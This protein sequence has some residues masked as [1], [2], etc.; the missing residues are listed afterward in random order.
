MLNQPA[1]QA[2]RDLLSL[3]L[4]VLC[5][6]C[7]MPRA[8]AKGKQVAE[9]NLSKETPVGLPTTP[10]ASDNGVTTTPD[11]LPV[12]R[13][14]G[15]AP[16]EKATT[17]C[18]LSADGFLE[19]DSDEEL[20][21]DIQQ[22]AAARLRFTA[23]LL[24]PFMLQQELGAVIN[25][26]WTLLRKVWISSLTEGA[27]D[28]A[29]VQTLPATYVVKQHFCRLQ[30]SFLREE[31]AIAVRTK[32]VEY[33][34]PKGKVTLFWQHTENPA[35]LKEKASNPDV[36][37]LYFK[38]VS[39]NVSPD[40]L[41][42]MLCRY[43]LKIRKSSAFAKGVCRSGQMNKK[44]MFVVT[45]L[46]INGLS[47]AAKRSAYNKWFKSAAN[48]LI[49]TDMRVEADH[50][51][52]TQ[53]NPS[54][55]AAV[56][57]A[58]GAGGVAILSFTPGVVFK[59]I[60]S[61]ESGRLVAVS[62][63]KGDMSWRIIAA[64]FPAQA[65]ARGVFF[66]DCLSTFVDSLPPVPHTILIG[67]LN[68][69]ADPRIDKSSKIGSS[70]ENQRLL[71]IFTP[72]DMQDTFRTLHPTKREYTFYAHSAKERSR[73][74]RALVSQSLLHRV[75]NA[76]H[77][78][79][80]HGI[81]DHWY[82]VSVDIRVS[83][84]ERRGPGLWKI[85]A[86]Q[87][88]MPGVKKRIQLIMGE[89]PQQPLPSFP[90]L[91]VKL[92][93]SIRVYA[94]EEKKRVKKTMA[95]L[96]ATV[97]QLKDEFM[98][99]DG[100]ADCYEQLAKYGSML[101]AYQD[102]ERERLQT[103]AGVQTEVLGELPSPVLSSRIA[104]KRAQTMI[105][106]VNFNGACF[107]GER[108]ILI[109]ASEYFTA[110]FA[111]REAEASTVWPVAPGKTLSAAEREGL[112]APWTVEEVKLA[113]QQL[114][115]GKAPGLDGL[116]KELLEE[117][118]DL[119]GSCFMA[120]VKDFERSAVLTEQFMTA[121]TILLHKKGDKSM[122]ENYRPITLLSATYKIVAKVLANR[123]KKV[124]PSVISDHQ[125]GFLPGRKL[126]DAVNV[127]A[128]VIDAA[129]AGR[130][131]WY[132]L[133][134]DFQKAYDSIS[135]R[136]LF[137]T[138]TR[139][140]FPE[141]YVKWA[142]GLHDHSV[143][144]LLINGRLGDRVEM[145]RGVR[146]GCPLAPYL[147]ICAAEPL[148]QE[149]RRRRL[150]VWKRGVG[151][152]AYLGYADD[153]SI[154]LHRKEQI[155]KACKLLDDFGEISGL[156]VNRGKTVVVPLGK[157]RG[158]PPPS[159]VPYTW[160][161]IDEPQRLLGIWITSGGNPEPSWEK[162]ADRA[163][164]VLVKWQ[165]Q[166]VKTSARV[167]V[168]NSYATPILLFQ[169][170]VY[171]PPKGTWKEF[172]ATSH[173]FTSSGKAS[174]DKHFVLWSGELAYMDSKEGG[175]GVI[176]PTMRVEC[177]ALKNLGDAVQQRDQ[178]KRWL[179]ERAAGMPFGWAT[180]LAHRS[181]LRIWNKGGE[182]W[183]RSVITFWQVL[184]QK[185]PAPANRWDYAAERICFSRYIFYRGKSPFGRQKGSICL[186]EL[187]VGDLLQTDWDGTKRVKD[188][189]A[190]TKETGSS[191]TAR[192]ALKAWKAVPGE[193]KEALLARLTGG[194]VLKLTRFA[195]TRSLAGKPLYWQLLAEDGDGVLCKPAEVGKR[196]ELLLS[197]RANQ[198]RVETRRLTPLLVENDLL[199]GEAG[200]ALT[201]L[202]LSVLCE[203]GKGATLKK[204]RA[205]LKGPVEQP[206]QQKKWEQEYGKPVDW[207]GVIR[208]RDTLV[209][210]GSAREIILRL[211]SKNLQVG[212]R[213]KFMKDRISCPHCAE[214]ETLAHCLLE[215]GCIQ[216]VIGAVKG[217]LQQMNPKR[218]VERLEDFLFGADG[219]MSGFPEKPLIAVAFHQIW[220]ERC[221]A[222]FRQGKF[223]PQRVLR[224]IGVNFMKHVRIYSAYKRQ[225]AK[226]DG[227]S[228]ARGWPHLAQ[229][230]AAMLSRIFEDGNSLTWREGFRSV[231]ANPRTAFQP[232]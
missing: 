181:I 118:W 206:K 162:A 164:E 61:H 69:I 152:V 63:E 200:L 160:A 120:F 178:M 133:L 79:V 119:L 18:Q 231:W 136:Y 196:G 74:D 190:L 205:V 59:D 124:L 128:D 41:K 151:D 201:R 56:S 4:P 156:K 21:I 92:Q 223:Q 23:I 97:S 175:L 212:E 141:E 122:L 159:D 44:D 134:V 177:M 51:F 26:V 55:F 232:P 45:A 31:D 106:E 186:L 227:R 96:E 30:L 66:R 83:A 16:A 117:N 116:P 33:Q 135:R 60:H 40:L 161:G 90:E 50:N 127:V 15:L 225:V 188:M 81:S 130:E 102:E 226:S 99:G 19:D 157:N 80:P 213:L 131:D 42:D 6:Q 12:A 72:L 76:Y 203:K 210:P 82:A 214:D 174:A 207:N 17:A 155:D 165:N 198:L 37:E 216:P 105:E 84:C 167:S 98:N 148:S 114:P 107:T 195:C 218:E 32:T 173:N 86:A 2:F 199:M 95:R 170:Q 208:K 217:A 150:G 24:V 123:I 215:C 171:P 149:I 187:T 220:L 192:W 113:I 153:T 140:G 154:V 91:L 182:K 180:L 65:T 189:W 101:K 158:L 89:D 230:E 183:R 172:R 144:Q 8:P 185:I 7:K 209:T 67:D 75:G 166:H 27:T 13:S 14:S 9:E 20:D 29:S 219:T 194:E 111:A 146:Q 38:D 137:Q 22:E 125:Y 94:K 36:I 143:T 25:M 62:L 211:H 110:A 139:M 109:A 169:A 221:E 202:R 129:A 222:A 52:W 103:M 108:E 77:S 3:S 47:S 126:A 49:L 70:R 224:K 85:Y 229:D 64:Y 121:V 132:L 197:N 138:L 68:V 48:V 88:K 100:G 179:M 43:P 191:T 57:P 87:A 228:G 147:F 5:H 71:D 142:E 78:S 163:G 34:R 104:S 145:E 1:H 112:R 168:L 193:W 35:Y 93:S 53:L 176:N 204:L 115:C 73:I 28:T 39:A 58:G 11:P 46:N 184:Q 10:V 54:A